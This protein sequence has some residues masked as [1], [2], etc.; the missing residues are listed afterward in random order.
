MGATEGR[1]GREPHYLSREGKLFKKSKLTAKGL[2]GH[3]MTL[4]LTISSTMS[5]IFTPAPL[6]SFHESVLR[7][8][9]GLSIDFWIVS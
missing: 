3:G 1:E 7:R 8:F 6:L 5:H 4:F 9:R 2:S